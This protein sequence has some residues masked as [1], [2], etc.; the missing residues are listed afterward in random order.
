MSKDQ[1]FELVWPGTF[2]VEAN[3][4]V[5]V[6]ELRRAMGSLG[7]RGAALFSNVNGVALADARFEPLYRA[8]DELGAVLFIHPTAPVGVAAMTEYWL[9]PLVGFPTDTRLAAAHLDE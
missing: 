3:L 7:L 2:V 6:T 5:L 8:A 4:T 1:L 9:M